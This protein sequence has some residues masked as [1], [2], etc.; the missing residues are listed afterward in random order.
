MTA[1]LDLLAYAIRQRDAGMTRAADHADAIEEKWTDR[2]YRWICSYAETHKQFISE[3]CTGA[4][5]AAGLKSP[6]DD[7][8]WGWPFRR[9]A[10][11]GV[12]VQ[13]GTG[14]STRRH[15]SICPRWRSQ[16]YAP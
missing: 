12:I 5:E 16:V 10:K 2:A 7:R 8:A 1:Q 13:D 6:T 14:R 9:A 11:A 4:A 3:D 15:A